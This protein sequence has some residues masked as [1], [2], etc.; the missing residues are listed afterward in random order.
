MTKNV[1]SLFD[2]ISCARLAL[3]KAGIEFDDY[4]A[5]EIDKYCL[6]VTEK[7]FPDNINLG[8]ITKLTE[9][10]LPKDVFLLIGGSP[11]QSLSIAKRQKESGLEKGKSTLFWEYIRILNLVKPKYFILENVASMKKTDRDKISAIV[12]VEPIKINS[13]LLSGQQRKR[14][15]WSNILG[16]EQPEDKKIYLK[17]ILE[18]GYTEKDKS[19]CL[20]AT[21]SRAC[22]KDYLEFKQRQLIWNKPIEEVFFNSLSDKNKMKEYAR[23]LTPLEC[24]RLQTIPDNFTDCGISDTQRYKMLGNG[25][26]VDV[27]AHILNYLKEMC[28]PTDLLPKSTDKD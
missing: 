8:D 19:Y 11:C 26:T 1:I 21:Y 28:K 4:Y 22:L 20:T 13:A 25:F 6:K 10:D 23:K 16:I 2:G 15:Y 3:D 14:L 5:S 9:K 18:H 24:E 12:G 17:D 27:I 7:R